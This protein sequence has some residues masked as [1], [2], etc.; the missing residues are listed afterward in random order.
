M[1]IGTV[2]KIIHDP[3][4]AWRFDTCIEAAWRAYFE[5]SVPLIHNRPISQ[6]PECI[7][8][9]THNAPFCNRNVCTFLLQNGA[10]WDIFLMH[11]GIC[12]TCLLHDAPLIS[13]RAPFKCITMTSHER[14]VVSNYR[15]SDCLFN[16]LSGPTSK[17]HQSLHYWPFVRGI[18]RWPV[19]S[20]HKWPS[21]AEKVSIWWRHHAYRLCSIPT[22]CHKP[23]SILFN[24][25]LFLMRGA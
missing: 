8:A 4:N 15:S 18:H 7:Y 20:S 5:R 25:C 3:G 10:L 17:K 11:C 13:N 6:I 9:I 19:N 21:N 14:H 24:I 12:E 1:H 2:R 22:I 16:S 23:P